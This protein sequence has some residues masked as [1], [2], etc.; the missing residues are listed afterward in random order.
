MNMNI[1]FF[2]QNEHEHLPT[3]THGTATQPIKKKKSSW[4]EESD[5]Y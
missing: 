1:F 5:G 2:E 3:E 4:F